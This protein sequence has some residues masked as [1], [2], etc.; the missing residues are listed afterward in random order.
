MRHRSFSVLFLV[1]YYISF[2]TCFQ[3]SNPLSE[4]L[5]C[6]ILTSDDN[7]DSSG[8]DQKRFSVDPSTGELKT[9][10]SLD[11]EER[12]EYVLVVGV[13]SKRTRSWRDAAEVRIRVVDVNDNDPTFGQTCRPVEVPEN[14]PAN[15]FVHAVVAYDSDTTENG[16]I[17]YTLSGGEGSFKLD[18][19]SGKLFS[20]S[21]DREKKS[22]YELLITATDNG[23]TP[24]SATCSI[25]VKVIDKNDNDP[26]KKC[27]LFFLF[28]N[29]SKCLFQYFCSL[30]FPKKK[31][32]MLSVLTYSV[33]NF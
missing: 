30:L 26:S 11:R 8:N 31:N 2:F 10:S 21:L 16:R 19:N 32:L 6:S 7:D 14:A 33:F 27:R 20:E 18:S 23:S 22:D 28:V 4:E 15:S 17:S 13:T 24:R 25:A 12:S 9:S 29:I 1:Q 5:E 3:V